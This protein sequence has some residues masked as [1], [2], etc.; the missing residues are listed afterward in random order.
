MDNRKILIAPSILGADPLNIA[1]CV[2]S[3]ENNFDWLHLDIMDG[4][5]VKNISFG[6]SVA[7]AMRARW[8]EAF[9]DAHLMID[10]LD[11]MLPEFINAKP[12]LIT[13]HAEVETQLLHARLMQI[14]KAGIKAGVSIG[15]VTSLEVVKPVLNLADLVLIMSVTPGFGGQSFI[16]STLDKT[17]ELVSLRAA[18]KYDYLIQMDGGIKAENALKVVQAGCDVIVMGSAV[19]NAQASSSA[20]SAA[21]YLKDL[22]LKLNKI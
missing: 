13:L 19:F 6:P 22:R 2:E 8:P 3:L 11:I 17:R 1:N 21:E 16:E 15:P 9:I 18:L 7:K 20:R 10:C 12:D 4:H 14:K 5:F